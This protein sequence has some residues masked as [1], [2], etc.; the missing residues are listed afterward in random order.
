MSKRRGTLTLLLGLAILAPGITQASVIINEIAWMGTSVSESDEWIEL[1]NDG[2]ESVSLSGWTITST[3]TAPNITLTGSISA[4][5]F[6]LLERTDDSSVPS[7]TAD[8]IY[9]GALAN[10]G[11]TLTLKDASGTTVDTVV[12]GTDW[13]SIGGSNSTKHTPQRSGSGWTT[14]AA[15]PKAANA[16]GSVEEETATTTTETAST[17][18]VVTIGGT[19]PSSGTPVE[20]PRR[21]ISLD[22]GNDRIVLANVPTPFSALAYTKNER[23]DEDA[24]ISWNFGDGTRTSGE[25]VWHVF[26]EPGSYVVTVRARSEEAEALRTLK[27]IVEASEVTARVTDKGVALVNDGTRL[28]DVSKWSLTDGTTTFELPE[29]TALWPGASVLLSASITGLATGTPVSLQ[30]PAGEIA[31]V[32]EPALVVIEQ[33]PTAATVAATPSKPRA[34]LVGIQKV[35]KVELPTP[36]PVQGDEEIVSAPTAPRMQAAV[37]AAIPPTSALSPSWLLCLFGN[38][39]ACGAALVVP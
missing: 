18:P 19:A 4:G 20:S 17:T 36:V 22:A 38:V 10:S 24:L 26:R 3:G 30:Y 12:G 23:V 16:V 33:K 21:T 32:A 29:D 1:Y 14:A 7:V 8:K 37:G 25:E 34:P 31:V 11:D 9:T 39:L 13:K 28:A 15:T 2:A 35:N 6:Y 27:V 5:G